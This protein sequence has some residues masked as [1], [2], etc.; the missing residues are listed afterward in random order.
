MV[1]IVT[2]IG[3]RPQII[4]ASALSR[5]IRNQFSE[6]IREILV[7]TG[8]HYDQNMSG[9][10]FEELQLPLPDHHL[11]IKEVSHG[12]QTGRMIEKI[13]AVLVEEKPDYVVVYGDTNTT[14]AGALAASK[15]GIPIVH[16]EAGL[17]SFNKDMPEEIN[18]ILTD[19][20]SSILCCP[21]KSARKNL[22]REGFTENSGMPHSL[23]NPGIYVSGDIMIDNINRLQEA[24]FENPSIFET[25]EV[26]KGSYLLCTIH[27]DFNA[28]NPERLG[29]IV[30]ALVDLAYEENLP[31][32]LPIHPRTRNRLFSDGKT[33][34]FLEKDTKGMIR[35]VAPLPYKDIL[36]L[37]RHAGM[38]VTDSGGIQREAFHFRVPC[39]VLRPETE[40]TEI[41]EQGWASLVDADPAKIR[42]AYSNFRE[43]P[44]GY[45]KA[46]YGHGDAAGYI[47]NLLVSDQRV[48][49]S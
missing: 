15:S 32:V 11:E 48:S 37:E 8:Q 43:K 30:Q 40:W 2:I 33:F 18:R 21:G 16:I 10:F 26:A 22:Y 14:L 28:D 20:V 1:R 45:F 34:T 13:E 46:V 3:A 23:N 47:C 24:G 4:K 49:A 6:Q 12:R 41:V 29:N 9:N 5:A 19:Q 25:L 27:R 17:R 42:A 36:T 35:I 44:P 38:I 7:H 31:V 39:M